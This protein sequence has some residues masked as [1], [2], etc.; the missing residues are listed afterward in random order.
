MAVPVPTDWIEACIRKAPC[1]DWR[2]ILAFARYAGMRSHETRIQKWEDIDLPNNVL[3]VRSH[4]SPP[5]RRC[6]IFPELRPHLLRAQEMAP[7]GAVFVQ[8]RYDHDANI[9]TTLEKII[10]RAGLVP[11]EKPMQNLRATRETELLAHY[12][13]KDVSSW[14]GNSPDVANKHYAMTMQASFDRAIAEGARITGVTAGVS[15]K[16][17]PKVPRTSLDDPPLSEDTK[18]ANAENPENNW[19]CLASAVADLPLNYPARTRTSGENQGK[20]AIR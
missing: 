13:A 8:S 10:T 9:L 3:L 1:E 5:V 19:V 11:W 14:L 20:N 12:P 15:R 6:P 4:K 18:K 2:I 17:P 7:D 16:V